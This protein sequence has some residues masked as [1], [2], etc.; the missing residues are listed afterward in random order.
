[1]VGSRNL[2]PLFTSKIASYFPQN[3]DI[4]YPY[5]KLHIFMRDISDFIL[6]VMNIFFEL[7][8]HLL[9]LLLKQ[10]PP[11]TG[12]PPGPGTPIMPS[13]QG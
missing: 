6:N 1:M 10:G 4:L 12:G 11:G 8:C 7:I 3:C 2:Y 5:N 13:P 9:V